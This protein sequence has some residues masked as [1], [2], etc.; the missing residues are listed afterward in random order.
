M[1]TRK[2]FKCYCVG[3]TEVANSF[4]VQVLCGINIFFYPCGV[5]FLGQNVFRH[6]KKVICNYVNYS[7]EI[8]SCVIQKLPNQSFGH[9]FLF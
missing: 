4:G 9:L 8:G 1:F 5:I 7:P 2:F 3:Y 6:F